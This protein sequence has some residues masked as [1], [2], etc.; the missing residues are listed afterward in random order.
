MDSDRVKWQLKPVEPN[1]RLE[2]LSFRAVDGDELAGWTVEG[3]LPDG[4]E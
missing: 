1:G 4:H 3:F 2:R